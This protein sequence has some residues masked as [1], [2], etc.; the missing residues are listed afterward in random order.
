MPSSSSTSSPASPAQSDSLL[1]DALRIGKIA[2]A[3][4]ARFGRWS[5]ANPAPA[6]LLALIVATL[7]YFFGFVHIFVNGALTAA[8]WSWEAWNPEMN[9]EHSRLVLPIFLGLILYHYREIARAPKEGSNRGLIWVGIGVL[10]F[11]LSARCLQPRMAITSV[12]FLVY[13]SVM[14]LWGKKVARIILF[15]CAFLIF[16]IPVAAVEQATFKLQFVITGIVGFLANI[17]GI[18]IQAIGTTLN[19]GDGSF[20]FE[21]AEGCSGIR[22]LTTMAMLVSVYVHLTQNRLWKKIVIFA[23]SLLFAIIGNAARIFTVLLVAR[24]YDPAIAGGIYHHYS[25][26]VFFPFA[27]LALLAFTK[28]VNTDFTHL[29]KPESAAPRPPGEDD[30][31]PAAAPAAGDAATATKPQI[32]YDY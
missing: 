9:Q 22:S 18:H 19:A 24:F 31:G 20:N 23:C 28:L 15:P 17:V 11:V 14:F 26:F 10:L 21:V 2:A 3:E 12:P 7:V 4:L 30:N 13:G 5:A 6:A 8:R 25:G 32:S 29:T 27:F 16:M 1:G